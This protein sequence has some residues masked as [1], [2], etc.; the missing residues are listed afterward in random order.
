MSNPLLRVRKK[1]K[2][3]MQCTMFILGII[4]A[5]LMYLQINLTEYFSHKSKQ[6]FER[7]HKI[8]PMRGDILDCNGTLLATNRPVTN[9]YWQGTGETLTPD[10]LKALHVVS[11]IINKPWTTDKELISKIRHAEHYHQSIILASDLPFKQMSTLEELFPNHKNIILSTS[12]KR[13]YPYK[14]S[15]SHILGYLGDIHLHM[16]GKMGLEHIFED[17][18]RG[19]YGVTLRTINSLGKKL[20]E[21]ELKQTAAG[22]TV[23]TT[24][25]IS[26]QQISEDIFPQDYTGA[27]ILMDPRDGAIRALVSRPSFDPS[28]F[29]GP[30]SVEQWHDLQEK[31]P[32]LNRAFNASYP[33]GS[34][35]KLISISAA[36]ELGVIEQESTWECKGFI[37]F[38]RRT[39]WCMRRYGH[40]ELTTAQAVAKSCNI[41]FYEIG[42]RMNVD[43]IA[44]Y[45]RLFGLGKKT[46]ILF[47]EKDGLVPTTS[48]K[49][50]VKGEQWWPGETLSV[51]IGQSYLLT[52]PI[53]IA[54]M[55]TSIFTKE[56]IKPRILVNEPIERYPLEINQDTLDF[57]QQSMKAV[58]TKGTGQR[59]STKDIEIY[60]KTS[61]AQVSSLSKR[62][63]NKTHLEH[64]W[65]VGYFRYKEN[66]PLTIVIFV[67]HAG[68]SR[69]PTIIAKNFLNAYKKLFDTISLDTVH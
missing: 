44:H 11:T 42:K 69:V 7:I 29:L 3:I 38:G 23:K 51:A 43:I 6:N 64:G 62:N 12:F 33:P 65:F 21:Q 41:L 19:E 28:I 31:Q 58:V 36:L 49:Q 15:A 14:S 63:I 18:L 53:Q 27:M 48:W 2:R 56:L 45:A 25:D 17:C 47:H 8:Q 55:I 52:T 39:Y 66:V 16:R 20:S 26:L 60:A 5:R 54:R 34:I 10:Q 59:V 50:N 32:F 9:V 68:S 13:Y 57:L 22:H 46:G 67:E 30:I 4:T 24:L 61:T 1:I 40:G 35:F 37:H